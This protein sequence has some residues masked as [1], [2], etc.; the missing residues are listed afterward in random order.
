MLAGVAI[1]CLIPR[2]SEKLRGGKGFLGEKERRG[3]PYL[4]QIRIREADL[5][6]SCP[7]LEDAMSVVG[8]SASAFT[9]IEAE[10]S[11]VKQM[12]YRRV[13]RSAPESHGHAKTLRIRSYSENWGHLPKVGV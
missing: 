12:L 1:F 3:V 4:R 9:L 13:R 8:T 6:E 10:S 7:K 2:G 11:V 5:L